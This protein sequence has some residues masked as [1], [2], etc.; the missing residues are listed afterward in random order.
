MKWKVSDVS[1]ENVP[2]RRAL[3]DVLRIAV[4]GLT[5]GLGCGEKEGTQ[6]ALPEVTVVEVSQDDVP[7]HQEWVGQTSGATDVE[8]RARVPGFLLGIHFT[9]GTEVKKGQL[10]YTIDPT[11]LEDKV[12]AAK[13][14]LAAAQV[15]FVRAEAEARRYRPLAAINAVSQSDLDAVVAEEGAAREQV[16]AAKA[17]LRLAETNLGYSRIHAPISGLIGFTTAKVGDFVGQLPNPIILNT[18]S[19]VDPIR[20]RFSVSEREYLNFVSRAQSAGAA[21]G[22]SARPAAERRALE[23]ILADGAVHPHPGVADI[24]QRQVDP[25]TGSLQIEATFPNPEKIVRPGQYA[26]VRALVETRQGALLIP[27]RAVVELQGQ[28]FAYAVGADGKV[29][30]RALVLGPRVGELWLVEKGLQKGERIVLEGLQRV[31]PGS[32]V[33]PLSVQEAAAKAAP[34]AAQPAGH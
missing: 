12:A 3:P 23:M 4:V 8:I 17:S 2:R 21:D 26:K 33:K 7:I 30:N 34:K 32:T 1:H 31:R 5:L 20:V 6:T 25:T 28:Y 11:E 29:E 22:P 15:M 9:E 13:A 19:N 18:L 14:Q 24:V 27:Q 10:L 16:E